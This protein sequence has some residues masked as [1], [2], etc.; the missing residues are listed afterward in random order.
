MF[1]VCFVGE[2]GG[3]ATPVRDGSAPAHT[4]APYTRH[5][6]W[7]VPV[8][9]VLEPCP[10]TFCTHCDFISAQLCSEF[11]KSTFE[12]LLSNISIFFHWE[13]MSGIKKKKQLYGFS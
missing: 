1:I 3:T 8:L 9:T 7:L 11:L 4:H 10:Q 2:G 12:G 13:N 5:I 6:D